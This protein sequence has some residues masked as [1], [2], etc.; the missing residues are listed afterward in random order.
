M[1][2]ARSARPL[3]AAWL[4]G[5]LCLSA[6]ATQPQPEPAD[7]PALG[8]Q[9]LLGG[10]D[11]LHER[12]AEPRQFSFPADHGPHPEFRT[13][14][15]YF[16]GNVTAD[17]GHE[18]AYHVTFFRN[19]LTDT[20]S[21]MAGLGEQEGE[22]GSRSPWRTRHAYMAH[23]AVSDITGARFEAAQRFA[24]D[25][26]GLAGARAEP[27][28]VWTGDWEAAAVSGAGAAA[29][30]ETSGVAPPNALPLRLRAAEGDVAIDLVLQPGKPPV[31]QGD[32]GLSRKGPEPGNA[33][34]YY[35]LTRL[36]TSGTIR[37]G[38]RTHAVTGTS[39][40]DREWSTSVLSPDIE[41]WDWMSLQ[42]DDGTELMVYRLRRHDGSAS[43]FSAATFVAA[44]GT[45]THLSAR[46]FTMTAVRTWRSN[47]DST[48]YPAGWRVNVPAL[49]LE[50]SVEAAFDAQ[51]LD[52]A[53][54]YWEGAVRVRGSRG[55]RDVGGRGFLEMTGYDARTRHQS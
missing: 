10:A 40:L 55:E 19:A 17:D 43:P 29:G 18:L 35:S 41:G 27:F 24:R 28:R 34:Y 46:D 6:C 33:S 22:T 47:L 20:T 23:F 51:E 4:A 54:R 39:W 38:G 48:T 49:R 15:W 42:L 5:A 50:L 44:D 12:A 1:A 52:L 13:E 2:R 36:P 7:T 11:T 16:T 9:E 53:V 31:L 30:P 21:F 45:P 26:V 32:A 25:A 8:L 37:I 14:W 3:A